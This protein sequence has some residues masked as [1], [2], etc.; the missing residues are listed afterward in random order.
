MQK[1]TW[2][3]PKKKKIKIKTII[4]SILDILICGAIGF[5]IGYLSDSFIDKNDNIFVF[6]F[7]LSCSLLILFIS[8]LIH[9][10][11][12]ETG[13]LIFGLLSGYSFIS[14][15]IGPY[16]IMKENETLKLKKHNLPGTAGQCLMV[17]PDR[18]DEKYPFILYNFG[19]TILNL[20]TAVLSIIIEN[21]FTFPFNTIFTDFAFV[22]FFTALTN[23]IPLKIGGVPND[24][25]N[26]LSIIRDKKALKSFY[27]QLK[28]HALQSQGIRI[29]DMPLETIILDEK[30]DLS[31]PLYT[32]QKLI[33][34]NWYL[35]NLDIENAKKTLN[36]FKP[37]FD[38]IAT[39]FKN[40]IKCERIFLELIGN[41]DKE[42][43]DSIYD[44]SLKKYI[45]SA[46]FMI[47][48][49]R[50]LLA[51]EVFYNNNKENAKKYYDELKQLANKYPIKGEADMEL[52]LAN[53]I[54]EKK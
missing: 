19:G 38:K 28:T 8:Y 25:Y 42:L 33:E 6:L 3:E 46:K 15:R 5:I 48:K 2:I 31:N 4:F 23:G 13:H 18:E 24:A 39:I 43:I 45:K 20:I 53:W 14:F 9:I 30:A 40:E 12:H 29:K 44:K 49:K 7:K 51:Y 41:C 26:I 37:Y 52:M 27:L 36:Q 35:D 32:A 34:Y 16:V 50:I 1:D 47:S 10:I 11:I 22:G 54:L 17:P 21:Y